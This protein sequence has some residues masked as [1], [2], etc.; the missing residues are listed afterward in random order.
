MPLP[1]RTDVLTLD[2]TGYGQPAAYIEA[3]TLSPSSATLDYSVAAQPVY[4]LASGGSGVTVDLSAVSATGFVGS[5]SVRGAANFA[6][7]GVSAEAIFDGVGVAAGG[8]ISTE[9][10]ENPC[11]GLVGTV[12]VVTL[13]NVTLTGV[14]AAGSLGTAIVSAA[15]PVPVTGVLATG[16][17][18]SVFAQFGNNVTLTGVAAEAI[19]DGVGVAAGGS[20]ST[21]PHENPCLGLVGTVTIFSVASV[22]VTTT[23]VSASGAVG[24]VDFQYNANIEVTEPYTIFADL[25]TVE[26]AAKTNVTLTGVSASG[27]VGTVATG[28]GYYVTGVS[29]T[30]SL[31]GV[32]ISIG[33]NALV[34][35]VQA[36]GSVTT[37]LVWGVI[38]D[39]QTPNWVTIDDSQST[40]WSAINDGNTVVWVQI[41]T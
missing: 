17:V 14:E 10:H 13:A 8:S 2:F 22:A 9:P 21:E 24:T 5:V 3:K 1:T 20:I 19:F 4:G 41:P 34:T 40:T 31:G 7:T 29:A 37:P 25:G 18:G 27:A 11:L 36:T 30:V 16:S 12:N 23:G 26:V 38:N 35:G 39:N 32:A 15:E 6:I 28:F 33:A